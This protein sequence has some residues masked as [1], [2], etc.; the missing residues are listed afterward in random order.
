M[1][2]AN[3]TLLV[4]D[5]KGCLRLAEI[6]GTVDIWTFCM[7]FRIASAGFA[8]TEGASLIPVVPV[9]HSETKI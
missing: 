8:L 6:R 2:V 4:G 1:S 9:L 5:T 3:F 7:A